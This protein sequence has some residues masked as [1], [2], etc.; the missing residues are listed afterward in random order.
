ML[1]FNDAV[2][3]AE[4]HFLQGDDFRDTTARLSDVRFARVAEAQ[5]ADALTISRLEDIDRVKQQVVDLRGALVVDC[6]VAGDVRVDFIDA[7][8]AFWHPDAPL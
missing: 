2:Y 3:G 7:W 5:G 8:G 4:I 6:K 1:V